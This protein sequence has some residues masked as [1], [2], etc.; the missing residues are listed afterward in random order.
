MQIL[1][2]SVLSRP[3]V[4]S[5]KPKR[6][7]EG[8]G[9]HSHGHGA[10]GP[11]VLNEALVEAPHLLMEMVHLHDHAPL[12]ADL[13]HVGVAGL[14]SIRA[15]QCFRQKGLEAKLEGISA[16]ALAVASSAS[17]LPGGFGHALGEGA[18]VGHGLLELGLGG[19][20]TLQALREEDKDWKEIAHG[21][22]GAI[23]GLAIL[24][25]KAAPGLEQVSHFVEFGALAGRA[26]LQTRL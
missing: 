1:T 20:E 10:H 6:A 8:E 2:S 15:V 19:Y 14:A 9:A 7:E 4:R 21:A 11:G 22:L 18:H 12:A 3:D 25:P 13:V 17:F 24:T 16:G 26:V 23:K 5:A